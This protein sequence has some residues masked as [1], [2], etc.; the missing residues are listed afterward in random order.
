[1]PEDQLDKFQALPED[2]IINV[3]KGKQKVTEKKSS[4]E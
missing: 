3:K 4:E 1:M 2:F